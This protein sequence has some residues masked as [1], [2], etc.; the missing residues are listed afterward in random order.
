MGTIFEDAAAAHSRAIDT[1]FSEHWLYQ[2]FCA[3][4]DDVNGRPS[5]DPGR[6]E[7]RI[8]GAYIEGY[9]RAFAAETRKQ[10]VKPEHPGHASSRP[11]LDLDIGQL[12][13]AARNGDRV[14]RLKTGVTYHVAEIKFPTSGPRYQIDLNRLDGGSAQQQRAR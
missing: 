7:L 2:P 9:A 6:P 1:T 11:Q 12:P 3:A 5:P 4:A 8:A 14:V 10:G 13:Y